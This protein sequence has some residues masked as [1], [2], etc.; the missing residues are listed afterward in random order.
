MDKP[1]P[2]FLYKPGELVQV[3]SA[4]N[5]EDDSDVW[6]GLAQK[7]TIEF[8]DPDCAG[9]IPADNWVMI[10]D[11]Y[12]KY[13]PA[14]GFDLWVQVFHAGQAVWVFQSDVVGLE[15]LLYPKQATKTNK[16]K[17]MNERNT[18]TGNQFLFVQEAEEQGLEV[19]YT[20]SGR[21]MYGAT[22][23]AVRLSMDDL[24]RV[25]FTA[26]VR[27]DDMGLGKVIYAVS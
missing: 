22:C 2:K 15:D 7:E 20:Y 5:D 3:S 19:D 13:N 24:I 4:W 16:E 1:F 21:F 23:P 17:P 11:Y 18:L 8:A 25:K 9:R 14:L 12:F 26:N 27:Q 6:F 10:L